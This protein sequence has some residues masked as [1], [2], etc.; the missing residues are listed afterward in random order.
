[1]SKLA[2]RRRKRKELLQKAVAAG[3]P[4]EC[5]KR[6]QNQELTNMILRVKQGKMPT[7]GNYNPPEEKSVTKPTRIPKAYVLRGYELKKLAINSYRDE[8]L[9]SEIWRSIRQ[10]VLSLDGGKCCVPRCTAVATEV[11][12]NV[13]S[14]EVL[15]G[16][17]LSQLVSL[18]HRHH[19]SIEFDKHLGKRDLEGARKALRR[20]G[21]F[22]PWRRKEMVSPLRKGE[23]AVG[24]LLGINLGNKRFKR[25]TDYFSRQQW[26]GR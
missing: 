7:L 21:V 10:R 20:L 19:T 24:S 9:E 8:Y 3:I 1:M 6:K 26:A 25:M 18:C 11:H 23:I 4:L 22:F 17:D 2:V 5:A 16:K 15:A 13:Y 14:L 12:H